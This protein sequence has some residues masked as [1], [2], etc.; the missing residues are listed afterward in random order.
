MDYRT[1]KF[2]CAHNSEDCED[3]FIEFGISCLP[4]EAMNY[5]FQSFVNIFTAYSIATGLS[6]ETM[7]GISLSIRTE[8][9]VDIKSWECGGFF[10][11]INYC[12]SGSD[13]PFILPPCCP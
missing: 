12:D 13:F 1:F 11:T 2:F 6:P 8:F 10:G 3:F 9:G 4:P 5:Y 7:T